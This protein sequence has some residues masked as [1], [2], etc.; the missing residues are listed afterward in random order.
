MRVHL[1]SPDTGLYNM[2]EPLSHSNCRYQ[3]LG[4]RIHDRRIC[5]PRSYQLRHPPFLCL[6]LT[7]EFTDNHRTKGLSPRV[8]L[9]VRIIIR[10]HTRFAYKGFRVLIILLTPITTACQH[11]SKNLLKIKLQTTLCNK[12]YTESY[13]DSYAKS[14]K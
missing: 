13:G 8:R 1:V 14:R 2:K 3:P 12:S 5:R 9:C 4:I 6:M 10:F 11:I 7:F